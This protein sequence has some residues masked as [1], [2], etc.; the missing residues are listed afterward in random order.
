MSKLV[1]SYIISPSE[2]E[3]GHVFALVVTCHISHIDHEERIIYVKCYRGQYPQ[4]PETL[5]HSEGIPQGQRLG[6]EDSISLAKILFPVI[7]YLEYEIKV[8]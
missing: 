7:N 1:N 3:A 5:Q 4:D 8:L 6:K 2:L